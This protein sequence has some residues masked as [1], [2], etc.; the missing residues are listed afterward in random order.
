[1]DTNELYGEIGRIRTDM[2]NGIKDL[3]K[4]R[5]VTELDMSHMSYSPVII[6][7]DD[8][9]LDM[10]LKKIEITEGNVLSVLCSNEF[11]SAV[12]TEGRI[13]VERLVETYNFIEEH[14]DE[15]IEFG[16]GKHEVKKN[17]ILTRYEMEYVPEKGLWIVVDAYSEEEAMEKYKN[18]EGFLDD[19][20]LPNPDEMFDEIDDEEPY[21]ETNEE[22]GAEPER[23]IE[24]DNA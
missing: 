24:E 11:S 13:D 16:D 21:V 20:C 3:M 1:M 15:I 19:S 23:N 18:G 17:E 12:M 2:I 4:S 10:S 5:N 7:S 14:I 8:D 22:G 6:N 9:E